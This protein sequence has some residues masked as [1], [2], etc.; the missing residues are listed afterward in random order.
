MAGYSHMNTHSRLSLQFPMYDHNESVNVRA[1]ALQRL[2]AR[3]NVPIQK[4]A[5]QPLETSEQVSARLWLQRRIQARQTAL[6]LAV[7]ARCTLGSTPDL[8]AR[9]SSGE[10]CHCLAC[11]SPLV[12]FGRDLLAQAYGDMAALHL[13]SEGPRQ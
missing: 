10:P 6:E 5:L 13:Q 2:C 12:R 11:S 3:H 8:S 1:V 4:A 7:G 9:P